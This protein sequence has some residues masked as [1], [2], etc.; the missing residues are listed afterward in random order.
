METSYSFIGHVRIFFVLVLLVNVMK[1]HFVHTHTC[2][3]SLEV[4]VLSKRYSSISIHTWNTLFSTKFVHFSAANSGYIFVL[5]YNFSTFNTQVVY[6]LLDDRLGPGAILYSSR[7]WYVDFFLFDPFRIL[8]LNI[9]PPAPSYFFL[10]LRMPTTPRKATLQ[11][12]EHCKP[13]FKKMD[14]AC[15]HRIHGVVARRVSF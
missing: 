9:N 13:Y 12:N 2:W 10:E 11:T 14:H 6:C 3:W 1:L 4:S 15:L 5:I 7:A 8:F